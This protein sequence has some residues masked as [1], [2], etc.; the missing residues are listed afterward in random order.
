MTINNLQLLLI[1]ALSFMNSKKLEEFG[2]HL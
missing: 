1:L 2:R